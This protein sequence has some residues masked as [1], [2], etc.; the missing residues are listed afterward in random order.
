MHQSLPVTDTLILIAKIFNKHIEII[1]RIKAHI[2]SL[3]LRF[4]RLQLLNYLCPKS[5]TPVFLQLLKNI[6]LDIAFEDVVCVMRRLDRDEDSDVGRVDWELWMKSSN[7]Q[8]PKRFRS[9]ELKQKENINYN[10]TIFAKSNINTLR[11]PIIPDEV[12]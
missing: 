10:T 4:D 11:T 7:G 3:L 6:E 12:L 9:S 5:S 2:D 1:R 8:C